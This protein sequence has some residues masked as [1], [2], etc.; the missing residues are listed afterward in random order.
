MR[1]GKKIAVISAGERWPE[2]GSPRFAV[3]D[4]VGTG[5]IL[6]YLTGRLSPEAQMAVEAYQRARGNL[7]E[8][9]AQCGSGKE[10]RERGFEDDVFLAAQVNVED[11]APRLQEGAYVKAEQGT[12]PN[13]YST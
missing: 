2:D 7:L 10:L 4:M 8:V 9:F 6:S 1:C 13:G 5:A 3:E 11:C 12:A